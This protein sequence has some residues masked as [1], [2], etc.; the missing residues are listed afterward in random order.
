MTSTLQKGLVSVVMRPAGGRSRETIRALKSVAASTYRPIEVVVV[1][2]GVDD[3]YAGFL[4]ECQPI[5]MDIPMQL[6]RNRTTCVS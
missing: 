4:N 3:A 1:Y 6:A 2:Q 5:L